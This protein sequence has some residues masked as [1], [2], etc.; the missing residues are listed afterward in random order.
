MSNMATLRMDNVWTT[1]DGAGGGIIDYVHTLENPLDGGPGLCSPNGR[2]FLS[3]LAFDVAKKLR[4][5]LIDEREPVEKPTG[6][7]TFLRPYQG[8]AVEAGLVATRGLLSGPTGAGKTLYAAGLCAAVNVPW[9]YLVHRP[10]LVTQTAKSLRSILNEP[11]MEIRGGF[12]RLDESRIICSTFQSFRVHR[13]AGMILTQ[14]RGLIVDEAHRAPTESA[15][16]CLLNTPR[17]YYRVGLSA[18]PLLRTDHRDVQTIGLLGPV[19]HEISAQE[20]VDDGFLTDLK[21]HWLRA[22]IPWRSQAE[23]WQ[24]FY[25]E[26]VVNSHDRNVEIIEATIEAPKPAIV[27]VKKRAHGQI[28]AEALQSSVGADSVELVNGDSSTKE[29]ERLIERIHAGKVTIVIATA[30]FYEGVDI[31]E[32]ASVVIAS[33]GSSA[34]EAIQRIGRGTRLHEGKSVCHIYDV[35]DGG[36]PWLVKHTEARFNAYRLAGWNPPPPFDRPELAVSEEAQAPGS[37]LTWARFAWI[38]LAIGLLC[39][40][41]K[42]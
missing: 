35:A 4:C 12:E 11:V 10:N 28:L 37:W 3:G 13:H 30:V 25:D 8:A 41:M 16:V 34:I 14:I 2:S 40:L 7:P 17:A 20:L 24:K 36:H 1:V 9:L 6:L 15:L 22:T 39:S 33:G 19:V 32:I 18:T 27:F 21:F 26:V 38:C 23:D 42:K 5:E 29:R 31:P